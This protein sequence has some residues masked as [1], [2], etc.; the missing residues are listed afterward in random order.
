MNIPGTSLSSLFRRS[1]KSQSQVPEVNLIPPEYLGKT[2]V[3]RTN[4]LIAL[5]IL[6]VLIA[7]T[8]IR[9]YGG[10][11]LDT[12]KG[13][14]G[15]EDTSIARNVPED[16]KLILIQ[17]TRTK[18]ANLEL[19]HRGISSQ[20][21]AWPQLLD[22][23]Y[24]Q[25]PPGVSGITFRQSVDM[26]T[27]SAQ[28]QANSQVFEYQQS[29]SQSPFLDQVRVQSNNAIPEKGGARSFSLDLTI[30]RGMAVE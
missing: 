7:M 28:A 17:Q 12:L 15:S 26:V 4:L 1:G 29:L 10:G 5:I 13:F 25:A 27:L 30:L 9:T 16:P 21:A 8:L 3:S 11:S 6:E 2:G 20:R 22:L 19:A 24:N 23:I 14:L 18:L